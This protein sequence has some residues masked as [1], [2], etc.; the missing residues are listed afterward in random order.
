MI[1]Q[2]IAI[3]LWVI[4]LVVV[5]LALE[6]SFRTTTYYKQKRIGFFSTLFNKGAYGEYLIYKNLRYYEPKGAKFLFNVYLPSQSKNVD[7]TEIDVLMITTKAIY[8]F[9]SKNYSGWIFG[10][11]KQKMWTQCLPQGQGR[12]ALKEKFYNPVWQNNTHIK[13]LHSILSNEAIPIFSIITFSDRCTLK[14]ISLSN[15]PYTSVIYR[16]DTE[17]T[18]R[19]I[20]KNLPTIFDKNTVNHIYN[21]LIP[22]T[23]ISDEAKQQHI[24]QINNIS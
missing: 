24:S 15:S 4:C 6:L 22:Y 3:A 13:A 11:D 12:K 2:A 9:E 7:S 1:V 16:K 5:P 14:D 17:K 23:D 19:N 20:E 18:Y 8:V 10:N 21:S